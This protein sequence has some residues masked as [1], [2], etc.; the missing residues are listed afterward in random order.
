M[1]KLFERLVIPSD[2]RDLYYQISHGRGDFEAWKQYAHRLWDCVSQGNGTSSVLRQIDLIQQLERMGRDGARGQM[3]FTQLDASC[4]GEVTLE[5]VENLVHRV[6]VQLNMRAKAQGGI[7][8]LLRKLE[9]LL[10]V[11]VLVIITVLYSKLSP[12]I[13]AAILVVYLYHC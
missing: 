11:V 3:L 5:E 13:S 4:D 8:S 6:G 12:R 2:D 10:T 9:I 7:K 1:A